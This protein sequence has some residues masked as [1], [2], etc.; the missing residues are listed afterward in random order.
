MYVVVREDLP[1]PAQ[2]VQS[3]HAAISAA[4]H[5]PPDSPHPNLVV[6]TTPNEASLRLACDAA[7]TAGIRCHEFEEEDLGGETTAFATEQVAGP[8]RRVF[9]KLPLL[10]GPVA[11]A[12]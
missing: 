2:C 9:R 11:V 7:R 10:T 4:R 8:A 12:A 3:A 5:F 6:C 1:F